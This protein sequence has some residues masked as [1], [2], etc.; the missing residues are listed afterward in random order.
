[1]VGRSDAERMRSTCSEIGICSHI[2]CRS[3]ISVAAGRFH[4]GFPVIRRLVSFLDNSIYSPIVVSQVDDESIECVHL[5]ERDRA[6]GNFL[7][8]R[9]DVGRG[10]GDR[11]KYC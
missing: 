5:A 4:W 7:F 8:H 11:N 9:L 10:K 2:K 6:I 3:Q 1:V